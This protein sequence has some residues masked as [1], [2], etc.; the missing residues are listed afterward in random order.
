PSLLTFPTRRT[1]DLDGMMSSLP[2]THLQPQRGAAGFRNMDK[3]IAMPVRGDHR[4]KSRSI[5][6]SF[7]SIQVGRPWLHWP[8]FGTRSISRRDRKST[9]LNSSHVK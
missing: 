5:S 3:D 9:R 6:A 8:D 7:N 4:P 2:D 1:S